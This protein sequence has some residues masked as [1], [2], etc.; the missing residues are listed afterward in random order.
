[1]N[2][3]FYVHEG[4]ILSM[5]TSRDV[6]QY[7]LDRHGTMDTWKLQK[8][9]YY[10]QGWH[11]AEFDRPAF[12]DEI[13]AFADGP[14]AIDLLR[15]HQT[16]R[17]VSRI[18]KGDPGKL[19]QSVRE[20]ADRVWDEYGE[21]TGRTL[22][23]ISH[24]ETAWLEAREGLEEGE[25]SDQPLSQHTMKESTKA[26]LEAHR[27]TPEPNQDESFDAYLTRVASAYRSAS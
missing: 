24:T 25:P 15:A 23:E 9:V 18:W 20:V 2:R 5:S 11:L 21:E 27:D 6:A 7:L 17:E 14:V 8:L 22:R 26:Y 19:L 4:R 3:C 12:D 13:R 10:I 16:Q 1:M